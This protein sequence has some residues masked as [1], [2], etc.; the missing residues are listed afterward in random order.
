MLAI[1]DDENLP[2]GRRHCYK[3]GQGE[4]SRTEDGRTSLMFAARWN[5][6]PAVIEKLLD[7][8]ADGSLRCDDGKTAFDYAEKN[9]SIVGTSTYWRLNDAQY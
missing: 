9:E 7:S 6:N 2:V 3:Q 4:C 8:G 1:I 5:Q